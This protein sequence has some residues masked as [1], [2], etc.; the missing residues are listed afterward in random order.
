MFFIV[1]WW[2]SNHACTSH[3]NLTHLKNSHSGP[4]S[5]YWTIKADLKHRLRD[6][7][8][9]CEEFSTERVCERKYQCKCRICTDFFFFF[10]LSGKASSAR[11]DV[12]AKPTLRDE[13]LRLQFFLF[14]FV[15]SP[16]T[17]GNI[18][19]VDK[20]HKQARRFKLTPDQSRRA[21][22]IYTLL[23]LGVITFFPFFLFFYCN[24]ESIWRRAEAQQRPVSAPLQRAD[25][26]LGRNWLKSKNEFQMPRAPPVT[27]HS[28]L[29][30][31]R[32]ALSPLSALR[33]RLKR[34]G[35]EG[36]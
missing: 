9:Q 24:Y 2:N 34:K 6:L 11:F 27:F 26:S 30:P 31:D 35:Q 17:R 19:W 14:F 23:E 3:V 29:L 7:R 21:A 25:N 15:F 33:S 32:P 13:L 20:T 22:K 12:K 18:L 10:F 16:T 36:K 5:T 8:H 28:L 1:S 4:I